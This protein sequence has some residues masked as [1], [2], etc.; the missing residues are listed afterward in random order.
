MKGRWLLVCAALLAPACDGPDVQGNLSVTMGDQTSAPP[1][2]LIASSCVL[3][4][5]ASA[6]RPHGLYLFAELPLGGATVGTLELDVDESGAFDPSRMS[7]RELDG[8]REL[9]HSEAVRGQVVFQG[10]ARERRGELDL[11]FT[12]GSTRRHLRGGFGRAGETLPSLPA[13]D[14][15]GAL[16]V[17]SEID[18]DSEGCGGSSAHDDSGEGGCDS[19]SDPPSS[20]G[21]GCDSNSGSGGD[22]CS[23][24]GG[25]AAGSCA[26]DT[27][28]G[29]CSGDAHAAARCRLAL[30]R[31]R[32][33][34]PLPVRVLSWMLPYALVGVFI[35]LWRKR[36]KRS[37]T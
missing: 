33:R 10:R 27:A 37:L 13:D 5:A 17:G 7:Y 23:G 15:S 11:T 18:F 6:H 34:Q 30:V 16:D 32:T 28:G 8:E 3:S 25:D 19:S 31:S 12:Q 22:S 35:Q 26:G 24:S 36:V 1:R 4:V 2:V 21:G 20:S 14:G 29:G 9:F